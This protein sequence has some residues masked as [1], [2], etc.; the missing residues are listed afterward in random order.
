MFGT[1]GGIVGAATAIGQWVYKGGKWVWEEAKG[2]KEEKARASAAYLARLRKNTD[3]HWAK[4]ATHIRE[5]QNRQ[6][7]ST[8]ALPTQSVQLGL[9]TDQ[10]TI[11]GQELQ[12]KHLIIG[13]LA[14][15]LLVKK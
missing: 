11:F 10:A 6:I 2:N 15:L 14:L 1:V 5:N 13:A 7:V 9:D 4:V 3:A 8:N 12:T